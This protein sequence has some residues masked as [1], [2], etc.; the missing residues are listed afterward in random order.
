MHKIAFDIIVFFWFRSNTDDLMESAWVQCTLLLRIECQSSFESCACCDTACVRVC[1]RLCGPSIR[2]LCGRSVH[3]WC[4]SSCFRLSDA[5][6]GAPRTYIYMPARA[7]R[8]QTNWMRVQVAPVMHTDRFDSQCMDNVDRC[9]QNYRAHR[10]STPTCVQR[11]LLLLVFFSGGS[12]E[13]RPS[14]II[15][16]FSFLSTSLSEHGERARG[17][18]QAHTHTGNH[19]HIEVDHRLV[20]M[21]QSHRTLTI[22]AGVRRNHTKDN[23][24]TTTITETA[25]RNIANE[26][27]N[28]WAANAKQQQ[29]QHT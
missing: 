10:S 24:T 12:S 25:K 8:N 4:W 6:D 29:Q 13:L 23:N 18:W 11:P 2:A 26:A 19:N 5:F 3:W 14:R 27:K 28:E 17:A 21:V 20:R 9:I 1:V 7:P 16:L 22:Q 15:K